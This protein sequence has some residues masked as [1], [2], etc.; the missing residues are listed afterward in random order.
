M[1]RQYF[2][3]KKEYPDA[4]LFFRLGDFYEMFHEDAEK[5]API[6][7]ITLT[8]RDR[9]RSGRIPMCGVPHHAAEGYL[10][11][12]VER[13]FK[14]AV[15]EQVEDPKTA[16]GVVRRAVTR[17][18]TPGTI[19]DGKTRDGRENNYLAALYGENGGY[20]IC[21]ADIG[22]GDIAVTAFTG[23]WAGAAMADELS[24]LEPNEIL[25]PASLAE[26]AEAFRGRPP[27]RE[28]PL[29]VLPDEALEDAAL[30]G[31]LAEHFGA[32]IVRNEAWAKHGLTRKAVGALVAYL[33]ET[34]KRALLHLR[35]VRTYAPGRYMFLDARTGR[36]LELV[37]SLREGG[38][39]GTLLSVLDRTT[40]S[41][42]SRLLRVWLEKPLLSPVE[43]NARLDAVEELY[44]N[45]FLRDDLRRR[46]KQVYDMDRLCSRVAYGSANA[47]DLSALKDSLGELPALKVLLG[48]TESDLLAGLN[49]GIDP[50]DDMT[51]LLGRALADDPPVAIREGG[52]IRDG[53]DPE[54][55]RLRAVGGRAKDW[56]CALETEEK[57]RTGIRSL[58]VGFNRV[59]GYYIEVSK[60]NQHLVPEEY[61]RRQTLANAERYVTPR[62]K[63]Y[64]NQI[65]GAEDRLVDLEHDLFLDLR[66]KVL[67]ELSRIQQSARAVAELDALC[68]LAEAAVRNDYV[69]PVV[70]DGEVLEITGGRHPVVEAALGPG[71]FVPNDTDLN[72][73]D[74]R[75][76]ILT[77]PNMAGKS[78]YMRQT[79]LIVLMAQAGGFVPAEA[80]RIG[81]VDRIFTRV[82]AS[83]DLAGGESTFM[84]EM[85]ECRVILQH[86]TPSSLIVM[87][88][89]GRGTSTYDGMSLARALIEHIHAQ[90]GAK[91]LFST[92]YHELTTLDKHPGIVNYTITVAEHGDEIVFLRRV[93][94][95]RADRSYGI[96]VARLAGLPGT[97]I[98]R[99]LKILAELEA[100]RGAGAPAGAALRTRQL[101]LFEAAER[102]V[103]RELAR[104]SVPEMTPL[105]ALNKLHALQQ[106]L[107]AAS[108]RGFPPVL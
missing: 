34:Q 62:L 90:V 60:A 98:E 16:K 100:E 99:A 40:T 75:L 94:P 80:A 8:S 81:V 72:G 4:I 69:R 44:R 55:D 70:D 84:V 24:R 47:R 49:R 15:C 46:L 13:G 86:A 41:M 18:V 83:D 12:L 105:E 45:S 33:R 7:E 31:L 89:V 101:E 85:N 59:F 9:G 74:Q 104:L 1:M 91:T 67:V 29:T 63:E 22:T 71:E 87:D 93:V 2:E 82:G 73:T 38:R 58:K 36:N 30:Q 3:I 39:K 21:A 42:G 64:E 79:A 88:E 76:M 5:A 32:R 96:Q 77:G 28:T 92:H 37:R 57:E 53:Y 25:V 14:V 108:G 102:R 11:K 10:A 27:G 17:V 54:V 106:E 97:L 6:L 66:E 51:A 43:I 35:R 78:T 48:P 95:G 50:M 56:L 23:E 68:S 107:R 65:L 103:C 26:T 20:G 61:E 52:L 19:L